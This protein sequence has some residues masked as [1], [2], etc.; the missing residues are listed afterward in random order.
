MRLRKPDGPERK[1]TLC[2]VEF[3]EEHHARQAMQVL[4]GYLFD[5]EPS[6]SGARL[7]ISFAKSSH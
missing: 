1:R 4:D 2:F 3:G 5:E 6:N 7:L